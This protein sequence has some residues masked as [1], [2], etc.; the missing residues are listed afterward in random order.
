MLIPKS[1]TADGSP[2][3]ALSPRRRQS[4][5]LGIL[6][7]AAAIARVYLVT[8]LANNSDL[9]WNGYEITTWTTLEVLT[10]L[11]CASAPC[12]RPL[13]RQIAPGLMSSVSQTFSGPSN[14]RTGGTG[15]KV[16]GN[17]TGISLSTRRK[18]RADAYE[19]RSMGGDEDFAPVTGLKGNSTFW[20]EKGNAKDSS[21]DDEGASQRGVLRSSGTGDELGAT[22]SK[23]DILKTVSVTV[24]D[25]E[26]EK[27][28]VRF[29][30]V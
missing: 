14:G 12:I 19:L 13:L 15:G 28:V 29:E 22:G 2:P 25:G 26:R 17:A 11:F 27:P 10:G 4:L 8:S 23:N 1:P 6:V 5:S 7:I 3:K 16:Y 18:D 9:T 21:D 30:H 24:T 20:V